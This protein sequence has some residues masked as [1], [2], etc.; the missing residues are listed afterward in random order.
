MF[1]IAWLVLASL[2]TVVVACAG[3]SATET[4]T[5]QDAIQTYIDNVSPEF[6]R[7]SEEQADLDSNLSI[8][9]RTP[10]PEGIAGFNRMINLRVAIVETLD[11]VEVPPELRASHDDLVEA[12]NDFN[13]LIRRIVVV[14]EAADPEST[15]GTGISS[16]AELGSY[17]GEV[18]QEEALRACKEIAKTA[19]ANDV[20]ADLNCPVTFRR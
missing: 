8:G 2:V 15:I 20:V 16:D 3:S 17:R 12:V 18:L 1:R 14:L 6:G 4:P 11:S 13:L 5:P 9:S 7:A 10:V 19:A